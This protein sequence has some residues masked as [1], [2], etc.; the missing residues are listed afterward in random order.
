[1]LIAFIVELRSRQCPRYCLEQDILQLANNQHI[2]LGSARREL[3]YRQKNTT[4]AKSYASSLRTRTSAAAETTPSTTPLQPSADADAVA[5]QNRFSLLTFDSVDSTPDCEDRQ[6]Q[7][8]TIHVAEVHASHNASPRSPRR[9][10]FDKPPQKRHHSSD[11]SFDLLNVRPSKVSTGPS[12]EVRSANSAPFPPKVASVHRAE[13]SSF[14][15]ESDTSG[16]TGAVSKETSVSRD[17]PRRDAN[18]RERCR[19]DASAHVRGINRPDKPNH[20]LKGAPTRPTS[21]HPASITK[22][23]SGIPNKS[24]KDKGGSLNRSFPSRTSK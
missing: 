8:K 15:G 20:G 19:A 1:M 9:G 6:S 17:G 4:G 3:L 16:T 10:R 24:S 7:T 21:H 5:I 14:S 13:R 11:E 12:S 2:S 18:P 23:P 22:K